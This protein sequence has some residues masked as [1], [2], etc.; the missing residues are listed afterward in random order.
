MVQDPYA[1]LG[2][3]RSASEEEIKAAY[4]KLA[5]RYHPDLHPGDAA[6]AA[7][8]N[9]INEAYD[10]IKNPQAQQGP[11]QNPY[12]NPYQ[13]PYGNP[14]GGYRQPGEQGQNEENWTYSPFGWTFYSSSSEQKP[15]RRGGSFVLKIIIGWM[16]LMAILRF[17]SCSLMFMPY[18]NP[19]ESAPQ[20]QTEQQ[21]DYFGGFGAFGTG[22]GSR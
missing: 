13:N 16:V 17:A 14:F 4:R 20:T 1:V 10:Q 6:C 18:D 8:M 9:E 12:G 11:Y 2:V 21:R 19:Q 22:N 5:K 3:S 7:R 15:R